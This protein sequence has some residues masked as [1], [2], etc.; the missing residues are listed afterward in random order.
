MPTTR[1]SKTDSGRQSWEP[2][3]G[4]S[5]ARGVLAASVGRG[6]A[7]LCGMA[8]ALATGSLLEGPA[9]LVVVFGRGRL[10]GH[11][12]TSAAAL[13]VTGGAAALLTPSVHTVLALRSVAQPYDR[14][15]LEPVLLM[16]G[17]AHWASV[18]TAVAALAWTPATLVLR[19]GLQEDYSFHLARYARWE[20]S[21]LMLDGLHRAMRCCGLLHHRELDVVPW[22]CCAAHHRACHIAPQGGL[23]PQ[24]AFPAACDAVLARRLH[25]LHALLDAAALMAAALAL[26]YRLVLL[27]FF[28]S[29]STVRLARHRFRR[30]RQQ[31]RRLF[32]R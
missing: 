31:L 21:R 10:L 14:I 7:L 1:T 9:W 27:H 25:S 22:S 13:L 18:T 11:Y 6:V 3:L 17:A 32:F 20:D 12:L 29:V 15:R 16:A 4:R 19:A 5:Q 24:D 2:R 8:L 30:P 26:L 23:H 28:S